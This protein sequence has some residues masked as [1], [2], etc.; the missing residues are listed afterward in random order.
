VGS[1]SWAGLQDLL[2]PGE[3]AGC[4]TVL[5][6]GGLLCGRCEAEARHVDCARCAQCAR[7]GP[8]KAAETA[9]TRCGECRRNRP[10]Y[11]CAVAPLRAGGVVREVLHQFKY[12]RRRYLLPLLEGWIVEA[13]GDPRMRDPPV[14][15]W[16]P[17]PLHWGRRL[18]RGYNQAGLLAEAV[19]RRWGGR[20]GAEL[21]RVRATGTQTRLERGERLVNVQGA[22]RLS[23]GARERLRGR[24]VAVV[25]DVLTTGATV[26]ECCRVLQ[27]AGVR[28]IR[29]LALARG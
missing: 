23:R 27:Q 9:V 12:E 4:A 28:G 6:G 7:P 18:W 5:R 26:E 15:V 1:R 24:E 17:V 14:E 3:C 20:C 13:A 25:D 16:V 2:F 22:M 10:R 19:A 21:R 29:I 8:V 11:R